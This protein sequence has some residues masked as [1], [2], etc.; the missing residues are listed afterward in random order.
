MTISEN[1]IQNIPPQASSEEILKQEILDLKI[2]EIDSIGDITPELL[3]KYTSWRQTNEKL[4]TL[5]AG[6]AL[7]LAQFEEI[8][9]KERQEENQGVD[10]QAATQEALDSAVQSTTEAL[11]DTPEAVAN[12]A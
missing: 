11:E 9:E 12:F 10:I 4:D 5:Q 7:S 8:L 3:E 1:P 6:S 2:P